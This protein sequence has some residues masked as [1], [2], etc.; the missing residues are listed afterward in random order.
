M[1]RLRRETIRFKRQALDSLLLAVELFNRPHQT[2]RTEGVLF[3]L[4]HAFEMLLKA[5]IYQSRGRVH[6]PRSPITYRFDKCLAIARS[7]LGIITQNM[8]NTL[9]IL[10]AQRDCAMHHLLEMSEDA[11]YL[12]AQA[13]V[14]MFDDVLERAF[15]ERLGNY[16]PGRVLPVSTSPPREM[17]LFMAK[18]FTE[19]R[20]LIA[21]H[22]RRRAEARARIRPYVIMESVLDGDCKQPTDAQVSRVIR[23]M[24]TGDDWQAIFPGVAALRLD[25]AGYG[26]SFS[27]R[28]AKQ[29]DSL[30]VRLV[31]DADSTEEVTVIREVNMIDR[32]SIGLFDLAEKAGIGRHKCLALIHH[33]GLQADPEC[34]KEFRHKSIRYKGYSPKALQK[35][36]EALP[37]LDLD[38]IWRIY[39]D[40]RA[41]RARA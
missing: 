19:I 40:T 15:A 12:H 30:P 39:W 2:S 7:D 8:A 1:P 9:S 13:A 29:E 31:D 22:K 5:A 33:L 11:L 35:I 24:K 20:D 37:T 34:F 25:T 17:H 14:T 27:V 21:P 28:F 10:D 18:E 41:K 32:Y 3:F 16:L 4:Q 6:E 26:L 23:R 36:N 38:Q